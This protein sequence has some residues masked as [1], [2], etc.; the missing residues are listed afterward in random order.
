MKLLWPLEQFFQGARRLWSMDKLQKSRGWKLL[1]R[2]A[3]MGKA[4]WKHEKGRC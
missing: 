1:Y 3:R 2:L 4:G